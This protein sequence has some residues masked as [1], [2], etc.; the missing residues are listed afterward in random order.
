MNIL[1]FDI[2]D[3]F[4]LLDVPEISDVSDWD[5]FT[6]RIHANVE[7]LL[8]ILSRY[9]F[10]AT[11]FCLGWI[12]EKYPKIIRAIDNAGYEVGS[13]SYSHQLVYKQSKHNFRED[14]YRSVNVLEDIVGKKVKSFRAPGFSIKSN[15]SWAFE[16][17]LK[18]GIEYDCSVFPAVR[19]HGGYADFG[20]S[21]PSIIQCDGSILKE[22]PIN[23][24]G[25]FW[26]RNIVFSGGGY[27]RLLPYNIIYN[28][29]SRS[30]YVMAYFHPRDFDPSQPVLNLPF[31]KR[32]KSY[33]GLH[34]SYYK[35]NKWLSDFKFTDI[36]NASNIICWDDVPII[37]V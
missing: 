27:F 1:T 34:G 3:W 22:F 36:S 31:I 28:L 19:S 29:T 7:R 20:A 16:I 24:G 14:V 23:L 25:F 18:S 10:K 15:M 13:H 8:D 26:R 33:Y 35:L 32:F 37:S 2:E 21:S 11:F 4:H 30:D 9:N 5:N 6:P 12:A 17:L